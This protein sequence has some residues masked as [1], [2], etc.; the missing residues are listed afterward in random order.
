[1]HI[2]DGLLDAKTML[3]SAALTGTGVAWAVR[4]ARDQLADRSTPLLGVTA[5]FI[6]AAQ[7][8]NF[9][10]FGGTSGHLVGGVLAAVVF[11]PAPAVVVM[12]T[13]VVLQALLFGDGGLLALGANLLNMAVLAPLGGYG[14]YRV[15]RGPAAR[16]APVGWRGF[17]PLFVA[18][19]S[20]IILGAAAASLELAL[21][22]VIPLAVV[23]PPMLGW[24]ALI[25]I[26]EG[27]ITAGVMRYLFQ[28]RRDLLKEV[29]DS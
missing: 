24:H 12:T 3:G 19:W 16:S 22:G 26:G 18:A 25:G 17:F 28:T 2:P 20:S 14:V 11:G 1:M 27:L 5:A 10:V 13:V 9:P 8:V 15:L 29:A 4:T 6:F 23:L 21:S 7:M